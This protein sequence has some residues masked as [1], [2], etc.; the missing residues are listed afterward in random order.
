MSL[1]SNTYTLQEGEKFDASVM[2]VNTDH[3]TLYAN[4]RSSIRRQLPQLSPHP[5]NNTPVCIVGGG[6]SLNDPDVYEE[7]RQL[8]FNGAKIVALNGAAKWLMEHNLRPSLHLILDARPQNV[9]FL[10]IAIPHCKT[11]LASQCAPIMF[12]ALEDREAY[13]FHAVAENADPEIEILDQFYGRGK[14]VRVPAAGTIG[15]T[16]ILLLRILGFRF[17]HMFGIDSCY[18]PDG[19]H[20]AYPQ[21][22]NDNEGAA[23]FKVAGREFLCS[24]WQAA[25]ARN[26]LD[27]IR[28]NGEH[29][30]LD[31]HG[32]GLLAHLLKTGSEMPEK[33]T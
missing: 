1:D 29:F 7:L 9:D 28:V 11:M 5:V 14:W 10:R 3:E 18:K 22:L 21:A 16:S 15:I 27:V 25:Q 6:W 12:D 24:A 13:I 19:T 33:E 20:H 31:I 26:F 4:I 23:L 32:D 8:Y 30:E 17:Q 2:K